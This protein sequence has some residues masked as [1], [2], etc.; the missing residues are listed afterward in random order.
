MMGAIESLLIKNTASAEP[1]AFIFQIDLN[2]E[3]MPL[4]S[5]C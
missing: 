5:I 4:S 3:K 1:I 2:D